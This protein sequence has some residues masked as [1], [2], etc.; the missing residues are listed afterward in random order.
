MSPQIIG[1]KTARTGYITVEELRLSVADGVEFDRE[2]EW[3]G[4]GAAVLPFNPQ[5]RTAL[6][7]RQFR[8]P[9]LAAAGEVSLVEACAGM[10]EDG[11]AEATVRREAQEELG[12]RLGPVE[13]VARTW[14]SP[15][16]STERVSLFIAPY[17]P[18]D[19]SGPG[20]GLALEHEDITVIERPLVDLAA[21]VDGGH[22]LD[23]KLL[24]LLQA[25]RL[26][27]PELFG[28]R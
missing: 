15:G 2:I 22:I 25:L 14:S 4:D 9:V 11:D 23:A 12:L 8:A 19:V 24:M 3:H 21:E 5:A 20:G 1:R 18:A 13:L 10:I 28:P 16:V 7:I 6:V 26:R 17:A 27:R